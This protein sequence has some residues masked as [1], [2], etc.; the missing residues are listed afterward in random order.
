MPA[1]PLTDAECIAAVQV[2]RAH[3]CN[4][5]K[6]AIAAE[7]PR[8]T[9]RHRIEV[10]KARG[11]HLSDGAQNSVQL[12]GLGGLEVRGGHRRVYDEAGKQI[13]T[14]RWSAPQDS[15]LTPEEYAD[16][17]IA[18]F[19]DMPPAPRIA[20]PLQV[21]EGLLG[22]AAIADVHMGATIEKA[23]SGADY[24][25]EIARERLRTGFA[26]VNNAMPACETFVILY[27][28]DTT[29]ANDDKDVTPKSGHKL[30]V[31]GSHQS[32]LFAIEVVCAWQID[33]ALEKH[34]TVYFVIR[35]GNH[36]PNTPAPIIMAMRARYRE[37]PRV[38][39]AD[40]ENPYFTIRMNRVFLCSHH[41]DGAAPQKRAL[42]IPFKF[43]RD[44]GAADFHWFFTGDKHHAKAGTFG[45]LHWRQVPSIISLEQHSHGEGYSD[46]SGLYSAWFDTHTGRV[47]EMTIRF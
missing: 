24:N 2:W 14:V 22:L 18:A 8:E 13:D 42:S 33:A 6:A 29:H 31:E 32:N 21:T 16:K 43:R 9:F 44:F 20:E 10:A 34:K 46:T 41:G 17:I 40:D 47:S 27:N 7:I 11:L 15:G 19:A 26:Q 38:I 37:N 28:G 45:G 4:V 30:K 12:A 5:A 25:T 39:V 23:E 36:D 3:E 35:R 1:K